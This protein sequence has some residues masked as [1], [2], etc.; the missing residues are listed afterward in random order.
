MSI[1]LGA[2]SLVVLTVAVYAVFDRPGRGVLLMLAVLPLDIAGRLIAEPVAV[3]AFHVSLL[4]TLAA[5]A[6]TW[7]RDPEDGRPRFSALDVGIAALIGAAIW[8]LPGSLDRATTAVAIV[9]LVFLWLFSLSVVTFVR[10]ERMADSVVAVIVGTAALSSLLALAQYAIPGFPIGST[11]VDLDTGGVVQLRPSAFFEDPNLLATFLSVAVIA[12]LAKAIHA[13]RWTH[14]A[15]W[16]VLAGTCATGLLVTLSRTGMVGVMLGAIVLLLTAPRRRRPWLAG[17]ALALGLAVAV[18]APGQIVSR[19]ASVVDIEADSSIRT[20]YLMLGSTVEM[21]RDD[22]VF[23]TGLGAY[24]RAYPAYR[25]PGALI[26]ITKP[27]QLPLAIWA[28]TGIAGLLAEFIIAGGLTWLIRGRRHRGWNV[29]E[30][31]GVAGLVSVLLQS[32]FQY[33]LYFEYL[34]LFLAF[35]VAATRF[36]RDVEE[37]PL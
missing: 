20:R 15:K 25:K 17:A 4:L 7:L 8:S 22:W 37:V 24:D 11:H 31:L 30:A 10:D 26:S 18:V 12:A 28:E 13:R 19:L 2:F 23:G 32:L 9:R 5:W 6:W 16:L 36:T 14:A 1:V 33:Y 29:Y 35:T 27:H 21:I 3:T 34:W